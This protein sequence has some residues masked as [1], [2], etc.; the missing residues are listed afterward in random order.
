M[1]RAGGIPHYLGIARDRVEELRTRI[2]E[3]LQSDLLVLSGGVSA[4]K[5]DL[6]PGVLQE[7][8]FTN[9][10]VYDSSWLG[11]GNTLDAPAENV[12]DRDRLTKVNDAAPDAEIVAE[13]VAAPT[14]KPPVDAVIVPPEWPNVP[15]FENVNVARANVPVKPLLL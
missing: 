11:Y 2:K 5:L 4:G 3:G 7:L 12:P 10:K 15:V 8:G 13:T 6:V 14:F 9:V 1:A